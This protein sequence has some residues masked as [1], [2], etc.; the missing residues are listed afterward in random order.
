MGWIQVNR[1]N[2]AGNVGNDT[3]QLNDPSN[4]ATRTI[5]DSQGTQNMALRISMTFHC[6]GAT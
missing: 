6:T 5:N 2:A 1:N 3:T 4:I